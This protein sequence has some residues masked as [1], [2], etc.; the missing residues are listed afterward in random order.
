MASLPELVRRFG[1]I[2]TKMQSPP[3]CF[4][5][6]LLQNAYQILKDWMR[7]D[8][9]AFFSLKVLHDVEKTLTKLYKAHL[10]LKAQ[11]KSFL[12]LFGN[13]RA[14]RDQH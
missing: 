5:S 6:H 4:E 1:Q 9:T 3:L 7:K 8:F 13:L 11:Y 10:L 12:G 14:L 2:K